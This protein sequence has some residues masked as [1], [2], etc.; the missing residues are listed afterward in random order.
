MHSAPVD[1]YGRSVMLFVAFDQRLGGRKR[2]RK[3]R[4][5][6]EARAVVPDLAATPSA[7][8][9][10]LGQSAPATVAPWGPELG[11][12]SMQALRGK[13]VLVDFWASWCAP[14]RQELPELD[15]L[16]RR[17]SD[18][19]LVI[20]GISVDEDEE[21]MRG[22]LQEIPLSF[23]VTLDGE[24]GIADRW[25]PPTMPTGFLVD[26]EGKIVHVQAGYHP[27]D[28]RVLEAKILKLLESTEDR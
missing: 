16:Y 8:H 28:E 23:P 3:S 13:V 21:S 20:V 6:G 25:S 9:E 19:G 2:V 22:F 26:P 17:L 24:Q 11:V 15:A 4:A 1:L 10:L 14:C 7:P 27:G 12:P 18:R 5:A